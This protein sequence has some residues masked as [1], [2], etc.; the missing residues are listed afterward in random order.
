MVVIRGVS[1]QKL[2]PPVNVHVQRGVLQQRPIED[3]DNV[4]PATA[5]AAVHR[6]TIA[7]QLRNRKTNV[8]VRVE[9]DHLFGCCCCPEKRGTSWVVMVSDRSR[10]SMYACRQ[11]NSLFAWFD[12]YSVRMLM[13]CCRSSPVEEE[14]EFE[15]VEDW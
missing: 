7:K 6:L 15:E 13:L 9:T 11:V 12:R 14:E 1:G 3:E 8:V 5:A 4:V 10:G 2:C